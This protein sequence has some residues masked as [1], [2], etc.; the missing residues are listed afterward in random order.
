MG[1]YVVLA[2][3]R[4]PSRPFILES[5]PWHGYVALS[6]RDTEEIANDDVASWRRFE[7]IRSDRDTES[8]LSACAKSMT[9]FYESASRYRLKRVDA[10]HLLCF[11]LPERRLSY[12]RVC[13][14]RSENITL[15]LTISP[16]L[17]LV[18]SSNFLCLTPMQQFAATTVRSSGPT[19]QPVDCCRR[20]SN[21]FF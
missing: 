15:S 13:M 17:I 21:K 1:R 5:S 16:D 10:A 7:I 14:G 12:T 3:A 8:S 2:T 9:V 11:S 6:F 18:T 4:Y 20:L 19:W